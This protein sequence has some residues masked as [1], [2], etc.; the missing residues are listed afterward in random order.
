[1]SILPNIDA[2]DDFDM[3]DSRIETLDGPF[4]LAGGTPY[5]ALVSGNVAEVLRPYFRKKGCQVF[6]SD[7]RVYLIE[8]YPKFYLPDVTVICDKSKFREDGYHGVPELVVEVISP[9][10]ANRKRDMNTKHDRYMQ[11]GVKE[12]WIVDLEVKYVYVYT[13]V[14]GAYRTVA[15]E[16]DELC[17]R[18][19]SDLRI[20]YADIFDR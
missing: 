9:G 10:K 18:V 1:M 20:P 19:Y 7:L 11:A 17:S 6:Q 15:P 5:H 2:E 4:N 8:N 13:L 3:D 16:E 14:N 12:Y